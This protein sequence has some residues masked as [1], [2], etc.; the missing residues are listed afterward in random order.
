M[1]FPYALLDEPA[2]ASIEAQAAR[3]LDETGVELQGDPRSLDAMASVGARIEGERVL[4]DSDRLRDVIA[5]A[6]ASFLWQGQ[7]SAASATV[8]GGRPVLVP[9]YGPPNVRHPDGTLRQGTLADYRDLV[10]L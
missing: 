5:D 4:I 3:I 1:Q 2:L 9:F 7:T 8:G 10:R 6:P